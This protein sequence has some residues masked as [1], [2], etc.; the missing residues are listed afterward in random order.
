MEPYIEEALKH[1]SEFPTLET[2]GVVVVHNGHLR[3]VRCVNAATRPSEQFH[4]AP[5]D[6]VS[7]T[8]FGEI[9]GIVHSHPKSKPIP[10]KADLVGC[11]QS[12]VPWTIVNPITREFT[13][14]NPSGYVAPL[15]G[16]EYCHKTLDCYS[17]LRDYYKQEYGILLGDYDRPETWWDLPDYDLYRDYMHVEGFFEIQVKDVRPGDAVLMAIGSTKGNHAAI[18]MDGGLIG[19]HL[20][21][22]L[23][24]RDVYGGYYRKHTLLFAR[25]KDLA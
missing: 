12:N 17:F 5:N 8:R 4:I 21:K 20:Y 23:S 13:V 11:E 2:C 25:H 6:W 18:F 9:V 16:R 10:S 14:T 22:R 3:Y 15:W 7:A 19:H 24:S 1:A